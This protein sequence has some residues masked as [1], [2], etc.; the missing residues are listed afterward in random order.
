MNRY[1]CI[2]GHFYQPPRE[3]AWLET[4]EA[5]DS[6][7]PYHD[8]NE[9]IAAE[10]FGPNARCRILDERDHIL[11]VVNNYSRI[12]FNFGPTLL[13][14]MEER[15]PDIYQAVLEADRESARQ[16]SGHGSA[17]AQAYNHTILPLATRRQK[18]IQVNW[19]WRDFER[20]FGRQPEGM[21]LP[22]TAV[23]VE[24]LEVLAAAGIRFTILAP[25]Q[26]GSV[27]ELGS[28]S[29][30]DVSASSI[31]TTRPY[32]VSLPSG[33]SLD[34]FFYDGPTSR[35]VAF[36]GL[37]KNGENFA[38]RLLGSSSEGAARP[39]LIHI[40]TDGETY[41]HH[42]RFGEM[43]LAYAL[44]YLEE[45][46][47]ATITNYGEFLEKNPS[48]WEV[49]IRERTSWSCVHGIG[50]WSQDC[51]C[52]TGAHPTWHQ[53]WRAP[54]REALDW[55][56][57]TIEPL[58]EK[59]G[60]KLFKDPSQAF[61]DYIEVI[62]DRSR[63]NVQGFLQRH[64][65]PPITAE[66]P[67]TALKLLEMQRYAT[68]M[69]TSCGWFFD[70]ISGI[71]T[72][73]I[74]QYAGR[75]VQL[76][77]EL[78]QASVEGEFLERLSEAPSNVPEHRNGRVIYE[79]W[80]KPAAIN[81]L[82]VGAHYAL[83]SLF[84]EY[85][86]VTQISRYTIESQSVHRLQAGRGTAAM[87]KIRVVSTTTWE[88]ADLSY[89]VFH[90]GD[91]ILNG[92]V[93]IFRSELDHD[94]LLSDLQGVVERVDFAGLVRLLDHHFPDGTYS[95]DSLFRD[96]QRKIL[97]IILDSSVAHVEATLQSLYERNL[98]LMRYLENLGVELPPS[99]EVTAQFVLNTHLRRALR[100]E[101][102]DPGEAQ[103]LLKG[104]E[105]R[106]VQLD[107]ALSYEIQKTLAGL[108]EEAFSEEADPASLS[109]LEAALNL[110]KSLPFEI[111]LWEV[112]HRCYQRLLATVAEAGGDDPKGGSKSRLD[113]LAALAE[114]LNV[115][116]DVV[117]DEA[118]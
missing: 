91:H 107:D 11:R 50:R 66:D 18:E 94:Q 73:Q 27:R 63:E 92:G 17:I 12:S 77:E 70:E 23:D 35:A 46:N 54:L 40:A 104:A 28:E 79:K 102:F 60:S 86:D 67:V 105:K 24:T 65:L 111:N 115:R 29:W 56:T 99:F 83:S 59:H 6:A 22:E 118:G 38:K 7:D 109:R 39:V 2:H 44:S 9:R 84:E 41:G 8:W 98:P 13:S 114:K 48:E 103:R 87:G 97:R 16:F 75:V 49:R 58:A 33:A 100:T 21:W 55:L 95:L 43:A 71:E 36:E 62:L 110:A 96:E 69:Y 14:W 19:G 64:G 47:L 34:V 3:N 1:V 78:F 4:I 45:N 37:L 93:R 81:L 116:V 74:I 30:I 52:Q 25:H 42:H 108:A 117:L 80:V 57:A 101:S 51:G 72:T 113:R 88:A 76:A 89:A 85:G 5:Q 31:D 20:R 15:A 61:E 106:R 82:K 32:R 112:Q 10:C 53:A 90:L 26:A 68:L